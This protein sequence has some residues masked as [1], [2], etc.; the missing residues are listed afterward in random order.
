MIL[1]QSVQQ[2][3]ISNQFNFWTDAFVPFICAVVG[4]ALALI[5][6]VMMLRHE[7]AQSKRDYLE[8]IRP[9]IIIDAYL[10]TNIDFRTS[11][12]VLIFDDSEQ[13]TEQ[14]STIYCLNAFLFSNAGEAV[15]MIDYMRINGKKYDCIYRIP[16]KPSESAQLIGNPLSLYLSS[17]G[18]KSM[19][20]GLS[21][22]MSNQY[23]YGLSF[24]TIKKE[25]TI[26]KKYDFLIEVKSVDCMNDLLET[27]KGA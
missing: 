4:G 3:V 7:K 21:D 14:F 25:K 13:D 2:F 22:R 8:R 9:F 27:K 11:R 5:G 17:E 15:C 10:L 12:D 20:I 19:S 18:I 1:C 23:E 6:V 24:E 26:G 16:L